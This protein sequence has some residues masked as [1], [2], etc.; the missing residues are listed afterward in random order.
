LAKKLRIRFA[1]QQK[2]LGAIL[3]GITPNQAAFH[4]TDDAWNV[5]EVFAH[6]IQ[7]ERDIHLTIHDRVYD[8]ERVSDGYAEN[9]A[10]HIRATVKAYPTAAV[11][12]R[13]F[14]RHQQETVEMVAGLP[15][16]FT[17]H[18]GSFWRLAYELLQYPVHTTEHI[19]QIKTLLDA[20]NK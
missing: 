11:I 9:A 4:P 14:R 10:F 17:Q 13:E 2:E 7:G 6:L 12:F 8:Q 18:K 19:A 20:Q 5:L 3:K 1:Q 15:E 16:S